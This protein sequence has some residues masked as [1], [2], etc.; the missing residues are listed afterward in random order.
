MESASAE[1]M[2]EV[3]ELLAYYSYRLRHILELAFKALLKF[4]GFNSKAEGTT[5]GHSQTEGKREESAEEEGSA[6]MSTR[7]ITA[8]TLKLNKKPPRPGLSSGK[9]G[10]TNSYPS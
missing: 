8:R 2:P 1:P 6:S 9:G 7:T 5:H 3:R 4:L 10:Q